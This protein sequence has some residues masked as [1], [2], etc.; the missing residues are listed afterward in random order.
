MFGRPEVPS[1]RLFRTIAGFPLRCGKRYVSPADAADHR[2]YAVTMMPEPTDDKSDLVA[3]PYQ[4]ADHLTHRRATPA[5]SGRNGACPRMWKRFL[6][7]LRRWPPDSRTSERQTPAR[8]V[9]EYMLQNNHWL[10]PFIPTKGGAGYKN[11]TV[12]FHFL[13]AKY[14]NK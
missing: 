13:Q 6:S 7:N 5:T 4:L 14:T 12:Q 3:T 2:K 1:G 10:S 9:R 8:E 11:N